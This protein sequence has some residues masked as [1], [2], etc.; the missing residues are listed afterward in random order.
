MFTLCVM[1]E[2]V[3]GNQETQYF[4]ELNPIMVLEAIEAVGLATTGRCLPLN[5]MENRVYEIELN[6]PLGK[7]D[8][9][10]DS[11]VV[12]KFYRPGRWS[13]SQILDEHQF[14]L[15][16]NSNEIPVIAPLVINGK[17]LFKIKDHDLLYTIFPKQGGRNP[18]ELDEEQLE[19]IGR[20]LGR[21]HSVGKSKVSDHRITISPHSFGTQNISFLDKSNA[22]PS[23]I[24]NQYLDMAHEI[25]EL[26]TPLFE[27][28]DYHRIHGDCH[29]GNILHKDS[30]FFFVDFDDML[31][32]PAVQDVWLII[33]GVDHRSKQDRLILL[34]AYETM[35]DFNYQSLKLIEPLRTLRFIHFSAWLT[36]RWED[37]SFKI[38]F[39]HFAS[40]DYW[41][42][43]L[44]DL[45][46]QKMLIEDIIN[47]SPYRGH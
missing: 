5:S 33:P 34:E 26:M 14:L 28:I 40:D 3:W 43:G 42:I 17:T 16:L 25:V 12:A 47:P 13:E 10:S 39:P 46:D 8:S 36:K 7:N 29:A 11:Y 30:G 27:N 4:Y 15:D 18:D 20:L 23:L 44:R 1:N 37:P 32:G 31:N 22:I 38:A 35:C 21:I 19:Q 45:I 2:Y 24:N 41:N 9:P 6:Q